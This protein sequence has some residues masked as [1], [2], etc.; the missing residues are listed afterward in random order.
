MVGFFVVGGWT[1][2]FKV[3]GVGV[4]YFRDIFR[5]LEVVFSFMEVERG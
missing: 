4:F 2:L 1:F 5:F 3:F